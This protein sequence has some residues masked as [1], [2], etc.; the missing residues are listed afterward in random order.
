VSL[1]AIFGAP[2]AAAADLTVTVEGLASGKGK[3]S[4]GLYT[5]SPTWTEDKPASETDVP[6][7]QGHVS[8]VFKNVP[9]GR[10][11]I[12]GFHDENNNGKMDSNFIGIPK[13]GFFFSNDVKP[14]MSAPTFESCAFNVA[15][16]PVAVTMHIQHWGSGK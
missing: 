12:S 15:D 8:Y 16:K 7:A 11:A 6:A 1:I 5:K 14:G 2:I 9:P 3:V 4:I 13:E 10:Y